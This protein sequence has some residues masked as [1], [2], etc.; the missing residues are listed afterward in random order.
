MP[1][2]GTGV[3]SLLIGDM[4]ATAIWGISSFQTYMYF[5]YPQPATDSNAMRLLV[6]VLWVLDTTHIV[7]VSHL[8]YWYLV[9]NYDNAEALL[10]ITWSLALSIGITTVITWIVHCFFARRIFILSRGNVIIPCVI[11]TLATIRLGFG[12]GSM[13]ECFLLA[14]FEKYSHIV[15]WLFTGGLAI[16]VI[17]DAII[18]VSCCFYLSRARSGFQKMDIVVNALQRYL[19]QS[20]AMTAIVTAVSCLCAAFMPFNMVWIGA[21]F[22]ISKLYTASLVA[23]L[24]SREVLSQTRSDPE[25]LTK[26]MELN[27]LKIQMTTTQVMDGSSGTPRDDKGKY[28]TSP[29]MKKAEAFYIHPYSGRGSVYKEPFAS[30]NNVAQA[31]S[32]TDEDIKE[33]QE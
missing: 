14:T 25:N 29:R 8:V 16:A 15:R 2:R 33:V 23:A 28:P 4:I 13:I 7:C 3:G 30:K 11:V 12:F 5:Y 21:H 26:R 18:T 9:I 20:G 17:S 32:L 10:N 27:E 24:N 31:P 1:N 6:V 19:I 22:V